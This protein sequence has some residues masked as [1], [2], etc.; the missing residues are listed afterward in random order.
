MTERL[1]HSSRTSNKFNKSRQKQVFWWGNVID[2]TIGDRVKAL[3]GRTSEEEDAQE[4][5]LDR[6]LGVYQRK[7]RQRKKKQGLS[8]DQD[9]NNANAQDGKNSSSAS[10]SKKDKKK[11]DLYSIEYRFP[12]SLS[13][14]KNWKKEL[15]PY[16]SEPP[17][18]ST[19]SLRPPVQR[20]IDEAI[21]HRQ[22]LSG[23]CTIYML[24]R[25]SEIEALAS[26]DANPENTI[27]Q[28]LESIHLEAVR[29]GTSPLSL[30][31]IAM[32]VINDNQDISGHVVDPERYNSMF[33][34]S[35]SC[36]ISLI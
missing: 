29:N 1:E 16:D 36:H 19:P 7:V 13:M 21:Q 27:Q 5:E 17:I 9:K 31:S 34:F 32:F 23:K 20:E 3:M 28:A 18:I 26:N 4:G 25:L 2:P 8:G 30:P 33:G 14:S 12:A 6:L 22:Y 11:S 10:K 15:Q 35:F 24:S